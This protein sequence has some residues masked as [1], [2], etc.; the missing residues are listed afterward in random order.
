MR[1]RVLLAYRAFQESYEPGQ[2][3][4]VSAAVGAAHLRDSPGWFAV[5]PT[6]EAELRG[7]GTGEALPPI[8]DGS[9]VTGDIP[10]APIRK[11]RA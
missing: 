5:E 9:P 6:G 1:L 7:D 8:A 3:I 10:V 4:E 2:V 11:R